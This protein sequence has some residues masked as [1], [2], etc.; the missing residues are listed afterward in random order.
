[1]TPA[2]RGR[3]EASRGLRVRSDDQRGRD[4]FERL[5]TTSH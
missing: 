1:M 5:L 2:H 4:F 3:E